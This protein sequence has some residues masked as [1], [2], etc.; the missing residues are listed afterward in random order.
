[1]EGEAFGDG[2]LVRT[3]GFWIGTLFPC[4]LA[5]DVGVTLVVDG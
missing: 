5:E 3:L 1:M 2:A 4:L